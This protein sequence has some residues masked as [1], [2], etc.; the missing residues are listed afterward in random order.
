MKCTIPRIHRSELLPVRLALWLTEEQTEAF[1]E[2]VRAE[3][4]FGVLCH[5]AKVP[6]SAKA[7]YIY[8]LLARQVASGSA[9][10]TGLRPPRSAHWLPLVLASAGA[11]LIGG[12]D[13]EG[14]AS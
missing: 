2:L 12:Q 11:Q 8:E 10:L 3:H 6:A 13:D 9:R 14:G 1:D 4:C 7:R 5:G